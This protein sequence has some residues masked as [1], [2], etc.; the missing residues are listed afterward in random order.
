MTPWRRAPADLTEGVFCDIRGG[1]CTTAKGAP[2]HWAVPRRGGASAPRRGGLHWVP[3]PAPRGEPGAWTMDHGPCA[4]PAA[5]AGRNPITTAV[6]G[7]TDARSVV[8]AQWTAS[9]S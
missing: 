4:A 7:R 8:S 1:W 2:A 6:H 3:R 9:I 5:T